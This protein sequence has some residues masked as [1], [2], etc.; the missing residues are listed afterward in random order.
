VQRPRDKRIYQR[1]GKHVPAVTDTHA[2]IEI[3]LETVFST[4]ST[5][6]K[7][8]SWGDEVSFLPKSEEKSQLLVSQ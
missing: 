7:E 2:T 6:C 4:R 5:V 8:G 3:L 1:L